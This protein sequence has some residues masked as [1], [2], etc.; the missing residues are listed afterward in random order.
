M[1]IKSVKLNKKTATITVHSED[2]NLDRYKVLAQSLL[3][4][5]YNPLRKFSN[6]GNPIDLEKL[7]KYKEKYESLINDII[8]DM[9]LNVEDL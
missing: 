3:Y 6:S 2:C 4:G 5:N 8:G 9:D 1:H 7:E